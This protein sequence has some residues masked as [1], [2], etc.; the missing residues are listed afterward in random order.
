MK[1]SCMQGMD[2]LILS[3]ILRSE[4]AKQEWLEFNGVSYMKSRKYAM[5]SILDEQNQ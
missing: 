3:R 2:Y 1:N 4:D 5:G